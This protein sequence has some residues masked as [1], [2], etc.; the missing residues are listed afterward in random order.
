MFAQTCPHPN[1]NPNPK[2]T[3]NPRAGEVGS[4]SY[5]NSGVARPQIGA[6]LGGNAFCERWGHAGLSRP[7]EDLMLV[8]HRV[9]LQSIQ[10]TCQFARLGH[11]AFRSLR[12]VRPIVLI[13]SAS[14]F[15]ECPPDTKSD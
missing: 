4:V 12:G 7:T 14:T 15:W 1:R 6:E 11:G 5:G 10:G 2:R 9:R 13:R 3:E 8:P